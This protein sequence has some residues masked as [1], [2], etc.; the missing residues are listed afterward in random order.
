MKPDSMLMRGYMVSA[1]FEDR[2]DETITVT[3]AVP[4]FHSVGAG[5]VIVMS[6]EDFDRMLPS[7]DEVRGILG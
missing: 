4:D 1:C 3:I 5:R 6:E 7:A 2:E